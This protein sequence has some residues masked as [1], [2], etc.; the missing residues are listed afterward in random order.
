M[1]ILLTGATG[2]V[3]LN[4]VAKLL[5]TDNKVYCLMRSPERYTDDSM[6]KQ[7]NLLKGDIAERESFQGKIKGIDWV[8]HLAVM[9][10]LNEN[11]MSSEDVFDKVNV[12]G[13]V[14]LLSEC[15]EAKVKKIICFSSTAAIGLVKDSTI[16]EKTPSRPITPYGKSKKKADDVATTFFND[17][18]QPIV[19][20]CFPHVYGPGETRDFFKITKMIKK[21][22]FPQVGFSPNYYPSV[23]ISDAVDAICLALEN[24]KPG[25]KYFIAD[26]DPHD[27]RDL[28]KYVLE[29][30]GIERRYYPF[31]PKY[32]GIIGA[33][34]VETLFNHLRKS[35]PIKLKNIKSIIS[36]RK[37]S[38]KKSQEELGFQPK[39]TLQKGVEKTI[40]W[41]IKEKML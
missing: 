30:L 31:I 33:Y 34:V 26:N 6:F 19:T 37:I 14:N 13:T 20:I 12:Q 32:A 35:P 3:G 15:L 5:E 17:H 2:Y 25:E 10:P 29:N 22:I 23:Y 28:R 8:V 36:G 40:E 9:S 11:E 16:D 38:I 24:G 39:I 1:N 41:M 7:C 4:L 18:Q 27:L 21:G